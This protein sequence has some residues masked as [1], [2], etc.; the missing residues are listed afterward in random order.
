[1]GVCR[2]CE[3]T[4][5]SGGLPVGVW[6]T[7]ASIAGVPATGKSKTGSARLLPDVSRMCTDATKR[8]FPEP[9][10]IDANRCRAARLPALKVAGYTGPD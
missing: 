3:R 1:M 5:R 9:T 2:V 8:N 10:A 7:A 6:V 4:R